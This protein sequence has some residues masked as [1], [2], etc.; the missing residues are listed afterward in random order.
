[1]AVGAS[2]HVRKQ[3]G[4][5]CKLRSGHG[6]HEM[7]RAVIVTIATILLSGAAVRSEPTG[8]MARSADVDQI[9]AISKGS[10]AHSS[11]DQGPDRERRVGILASLARIPATSDRGAPATADS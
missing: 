5:G 11:R 10:A 9:L 6:R 2:R 8:A 1:M 7:N 4:V 3:Q